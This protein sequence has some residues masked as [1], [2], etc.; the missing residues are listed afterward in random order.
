MFFNFHWFDMKMTVGLIELMIND[1]EG[2]L[3]FYLDLFQFSLLTQESKEGKMYW[4]LVSLKGFL[5]SFKDE[6]R[7]KQEVLF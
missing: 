4:A 1:M 3:S 6:R 7:L 5:L 2:A